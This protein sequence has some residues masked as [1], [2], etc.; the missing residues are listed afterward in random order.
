SEGGDNTRGWYPGGNTVCKGIGGI[1]GSS[2]RSNRHLKSRK[3][4]RKCIR[5][6]SWDLQST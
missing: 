3:Q 2:I 1:L 5:P 4:Y 6:R